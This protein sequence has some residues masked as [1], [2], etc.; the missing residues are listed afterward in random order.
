MITASCKRA[1]NIDLDPPVPF[2]FIII[3]FYYIW[4][5]F[6]S[7]LVKSECHC[8]T[9]F[10]CMWMSTNLNVNDCCIA[11]R[12]LSFILF[13]RSIVSPLVGKCSCA[14]NQIIRETYVGFH[15]FIY[16][17]IQYIL[18]APPG[19][20]MFYVYCSIDNC[21]ILIALLWVHVRLKHYY[22]QLQRLYDWCVW[23]LSYQKIFPIARVLVI[24]WN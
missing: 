16:V 22:W 6:Q 14:G 18:I 8:Q 12:S 2:F 7:I 13:F 17:F 10:I 24:T 15:S 1:G 20:P 5:E 9:F 21:L 4:I 19:V 3:S 11:L 23:V